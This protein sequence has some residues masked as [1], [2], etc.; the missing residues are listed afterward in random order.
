MKN[1]R[2]RKYLFALLVLVLVFA[3]CKGESPTAPPV[4]SGPGAP[5][6]PPTGANITLTVVNPTPFAGSST[7]IRAT[8]TQ[9][10]T[11]VPNGTAVEFSTTRGVFQDTGQNASLRTTTNGIATVILSST[12]S[13]IATVRAVVNNVSQTTTVEFKVVDPGP[14]PP[15]ATNPQITS[16][17]PQFAPPTGGTLVTIRGKNF[18]PPVKVFLDFGSGNLREATVTSVSADTITFLTPVVDLGVGQQATANI[19]VFFEQGTPAE[20]SITFGTP[21]TFQKAVLTPVIRAV[22]PASGGIDGGT[23]VTIF[24]EGFESPAQLFFGAAEAPIVNLTFSQIIAIAPPGRDTSAD[25]SGAVTGPIAIR[26]ININSGTEGSLAAGFRYTPKMQI[27]AAGPTEGPFT[28]G[29]RVTIDGTGFDSPVAVSIGGV[30]AQPVF[31]SGTRVI[32]VT[33]GVAVTAC[34]DQTGPITVTNIDNGD[35]A[36][37]PTFTFRVLKPVILSVSGSAAPGGTVTIVVLNAIGIDRLQIGDK[38]VSIT[39]AVEN[40][41]GTTTFTAVVP[42]TLTLDTQA[43]EGLTGVNV[44]IPTD[45]DVVYTSLTTGCTDTLAAGAT[46][47]PPAA[48]RISL[49]P[50]AFTLPFQAT[51]T[52]ADPAA[53][54]PTPA[55]VAPSPSQTLTLANNGTAPLTITSATHNCSA[56]FVVSLPPAGTTLNTCDAT[57]ISAQFN[58]NVASGTPFNESCQITIVTNAGTRVLQVQGSQ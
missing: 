53:V 51:F 38:N 4:N 13:G 41:D 22:S 40:P 15:T 31:V 21:F 37:G 49:T 56:N 25:G 12:S 32:A 29:T 8:V 6:T 9:N 17:S 42:A 48:A 36:I 57:G 43:C 18:K 3:G 26:V 7:E 2:Q 52:P 11:P 39:S 14:P 5:G 34:A 1:L 54:P 10:N 44:P 45:F 46:I 19:L 33:P 50:S 20:T 16:V 30:A 58:G 55:S 24:G 35:Q 27:T 23:R 47:N 28:G